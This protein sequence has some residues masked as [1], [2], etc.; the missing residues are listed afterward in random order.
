M[1]S[2]RKP[3]LDKLFQNKEKTREVGLE[4]SQP[5]ITPISER[6]LWEGIRVG[7]AGGLLENQFEQKEGSSVPS[8]VKLKPTVYKVCIIYVREYE[9]T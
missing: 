7:I 9:S 5:G 6:T 1:L 2:V 8:S 3:S 4:G